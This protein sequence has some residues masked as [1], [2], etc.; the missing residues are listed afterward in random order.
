MILTE[1]E[2]ALNAF[3]QIFCMI[4]QIVSVHAVSLSISGFSQKE[5]GPVCDL[6]TEAQIIKILNKYVVE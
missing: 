1:K 4:I 6:S 3:V 5:D 2:C